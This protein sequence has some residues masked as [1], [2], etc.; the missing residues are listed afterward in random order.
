MSLEAIKSL[1]NLFEN[2]KINSKVKS[3]KKENSFFV[4]DVDLNSTG[5]F[6]KIERFST[7]IALTL[8]S[9]S[10]PLIY[11]V[12]KEGVVRIESMQEEPED[13]F[14]NDVV[15]NNDTSNYVL[16]IA[17]GNKKDN[18]PLVFDLVEMPHLLIAGTT[19]SGKSILLHTIINNLLISDKKYKLALIDPKRVEFTYYEKCSKLYAPI[20]K[21]VEESIKLLDDLIVE[22]DSRFEI[23]EKN[24]CR[25][26]A[27]YNGKMDYIVVV[28][29]ELADL[30]MASRK[31]AQDQICRLAQKSRSCGIHLVVATQ[32]PSVDVVTGLI[33]ANFPVRISCKVSAAIDSRVIL[34]KNGAE[35]LVGKGDAIIDGMKFK[36]DRFKVA[37]IS[38]EQIKHNVEKNQSW[39]HQ[40][41][42]F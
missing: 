18:S 29:D 26:I 3:C 15:K 32:R 23:L 41:W 22:M 30:M 5:T 38:N 36:F 27:E 14:F 39:W 42:N 20:A 24:N 16:P 10:L 19:G 17:I 33:K 13:V 25:S 11:P 31:A 8:R 37:Y 12:T 28:I 4:F 2:L 6:K 34:D 21:N 7:E 9:Y 40:I 1:N 35:K